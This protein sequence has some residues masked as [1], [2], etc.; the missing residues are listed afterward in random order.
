MWGNRSKDCTKIPKKKICKKNQKKVEK[1]INQAENATC[2]PATVRARLPATLKIWV[3]TFQRK[4]IFGSFSHF[5]DIWLLWF[6]K[7]LIFEAWNPSNFGDITDS[8][9][10][11]WVFHPTPRNR[12][13]CNQERT[14]REI[15]ICLI[16]REIDR[17]YGIGPP[18]TITVWNCMIIQRQLMQEIHRRSRLPTSRVGFQ[19]SRHGSWLFKCFGSHLMRLINHYY[20]RPNQN[21]RNGSYKSIQL[22]Y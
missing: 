3:A 8:P 13:P 6:S 11:S 18:A 15:N 14:F 16:D 9:S 17:T 21:P 2:S 12:E 4:P 10:K 19:K 20:E 5:Q 22:W 1:A 7:N